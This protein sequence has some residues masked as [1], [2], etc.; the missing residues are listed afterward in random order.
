MERTYEQQIRD[1]IDGLAQ[2]VTLTQGMVKDLMN[3]KLHSSLMYCASL[4]SPFTF[5][6][7]KKRMYSKCETNLVVVHPKGLTHFEQMCYFLSEI[8]DTN[9]FIEYEN[10]ENRI[11]GFAQSTNKKQIR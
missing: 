10:G 5:E 6:E 3:L 4:K 8:I 7:L 9:I 2:N 11:F 1:T